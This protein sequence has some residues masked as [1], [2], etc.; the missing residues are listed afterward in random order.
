MPIYRYRCECGEEVEIIAPIAERDNPKPHCGLRMTRLMTSPFPARFPET[1]KDRCL[2]V[3]N[4]VDGWDFNSYPEDR[5]KLERQ[6]AQGL[7]P[8]KPVIGK[9]F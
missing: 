8:P 9:G 1:G 7:D 6:Y 5:K 3:L 2:K 4:H